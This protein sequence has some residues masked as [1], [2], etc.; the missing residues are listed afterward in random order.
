MKFKLLIFDFDGTIVDSNKGIFNSISFVLEQL[1][2]SEELMFKQYFQQIGKPLYNQFLEFLPEKKQLL[3]KEA[4]ELYCKH[5]KEH[6]IKQTR[7]FEN[8]KEV[9]LEFK[10]EGR[11]LAI[12]SSKPNWLLSIFLEMF[13]MQDLF[14]MVVGEDSVIFLKP[15]P[16]GIERILIDLNIEKENALYIG[17]N[18]IDSLTGKNANVKTIIL[19][20]NK[21][22]NFLTLKE[23]IKKQER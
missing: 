14:D 23:F 7:L 22:S 9:L 15:A 2:C 5:Y 8:A 4:C 17:D 16:E 18:G 20:H 19:N 21:K 1:G 13:E 3:A 12:F 11:K 6:G 10:K